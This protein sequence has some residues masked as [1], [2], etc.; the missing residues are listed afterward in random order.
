MCWALTT[1]LVLLSVLLEAE[2][3]AAALPAWRLE[4]QRVDN[5]SVPVALGTLLAICLRSREC[6]H[7]Y[8][9]NPRAPNAVVFRHLLPTGALDKPLLEPLQSL[10]ESAS[11][12]TANEQLWLL[13][14]SAYRRSVGYLCDVNHE[15]VFDQQTLQTNC[16]CKPD[17]TCSDELYTLL[18]FWIALGLAVVLGLLLFA[19]VVYTKKKQLDKIEAIGNNEGDKFRILFMAFN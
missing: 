19:G 12:E 2:A 15:V 8:H 9:L 16:V 3:E 13:R 7:A 17:A 18:P 5:G 10:M 4:P 6:K 1:S 11:P 14:L